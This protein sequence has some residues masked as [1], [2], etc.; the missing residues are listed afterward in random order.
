MI[1]Y[2]FF[3]IPFLLIG[4][5]YSYGAEIDHAYDEITTAFSGTAN[6]WTEVENLSLTS[7]NFTVGNKYLIVVTSQMNLNNGVSERVE[8]RILHDTTVFTGSTQS[9]EVGTIPYTDYAWFTVWTAVSSEDITMQVKGS[10][11]LG[12]VDVDQASIFA[13]EISEDLT[14]DTDWFFDEVTASVSLTTTWSKVSNA[15]VAFTPNGSDEYLILSTSD[16]RA[17]STTTNVESRINRTNTDFTPRASN[18]GQTGSDI[19]IF[20][21]SRVYTPANSAQTFAQESRNDGTSSGTREYSAI[22]ALNLDSFSQHSSA[23]TVAELNHDTTNNF[24][25]STQ[26]QTVSIT[27]SVEGDY[28]AIWTSI[29]DGGINPKDRLQID[30]AD[31]PATQTSDFYPRHVGYDAT[32]QPAVF[33]QTVK[34]L[35]TS[36]H[37]ID[38]DATGAGLA[39]PYEDRHITVLSMELPSA[40]GDSA[41]SASDDLAVEETLTQRMDHTRSLADD[42]A[43]EETL[44]QGMN[45]NRDLAD[46]FAVEE[47]LVGST[48]IQKTASDD[49]AVEETL[50]QRM[51]HARSLADE[52]ALE[53]TLTNSLPTNKAISDDFAL[54]ETLTQRMDHNR[55][56]SDDFALEESIGRVLVIGGKSLPPS[57]A[58]EFA[59]EETITQR[60][61]HARSLAD[62]FALEE[63]IVGSLDMQEIAD[64]LALEESLT[65]VCSGCVPPSLNAIILALNSPLNDRLGGV[66]SIVCPA[67]HTLTGLFT[68][69]TFICTDLADFFP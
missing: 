4:F 24:A 33:V 20:T 36:A 62:E 56:I 27:P 10:S 11:T 41:R 5:H 46:D 2:I 30:N 13:M 60:M 42:F 39:T 21:I 52:F 29:H 32:R 40:G 66:F 57:G 18:E 45:H 15:E 14:E 55:N 3:L 43:V 64:N 59:V 1:K 65:F 19:Y 69:G 49:F 53:E 35:A 34:S 38:A 51:D 25:T 22:F 23:Y 12:V 63:S 47:T 16:L 48:A 68:N 9:R 8:A 28:W 6:V 17:S 44:T 54:E 31:S 58:E 26:M 7:G 37:N 61:D 67:N 50:T